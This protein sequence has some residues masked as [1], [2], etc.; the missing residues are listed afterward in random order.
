ML[1]TRQVREKTKDVTRRLGWEYLKK[2]ELLQGCEKCQGRKPGEPIVKLA[3]VKV[4]SVRREPLR[5]LTDD[6]VYGAAEVRREGF[7]EMTPAAFVEF[8]CNSHE[9]CTP[10][11]K[12]A[13]IEFG[14][15]E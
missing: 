8:F 6:P 12:V 14:Y 1:T 11:T 9:K 15:V 5:A 4:V 3:V 10:D 2:G 13:R 7:P